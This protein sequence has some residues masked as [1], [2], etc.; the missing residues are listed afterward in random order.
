MI[1]L[2]IFGSWVTK[3][4]MMSDGMTAGMVSAAQALPLALRSVLL[5]FCAVNFTKAMEFDDNLE[6]ENARIAME[7]ATMYA[8]CITRTF[9]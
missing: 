4:F 3:E 2:L 1:T 7:S 8:H 9:E 6:Q 5:N